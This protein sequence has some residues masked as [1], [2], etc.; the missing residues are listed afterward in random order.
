MSGSGK[1]KGL[2]RVPSKLLFAEDEDDDDDEEIRFT[3]KAPRS[4]SS[5]GSRKCQ[6]CPS[7]CFST[8]RGVRTPMGSQAEGGSSRGRTDTEMSSPSRSS[9]HKGN[10]G[11]M[12]K[13]MKDSWVEVLDANGKAYFWEV[14][15]PHCVQRNRPDLSP[16]LLV[17]KEGEL[18]DL[19]AQVVEENTAA[20]D[21]NRFV[22]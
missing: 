16:G 19:N 10:T 6:L 11:S 3:E 5:S 18:V 8:P 21:G 12:M 9:L 14:N 20:A 22:T 1:N 17:F 7:C 15:T 13:V 2:K 4:P